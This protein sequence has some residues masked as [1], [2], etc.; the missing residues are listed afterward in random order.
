MSWRTPCST[1]M[2]G[3]QMRDSFLVR[4]VCFAIGSGN[5]ERK[6]LCSLIRVVLTHQ[7]CVTYQFTAVRCEGRQ[8]AGCVTAAAK[9][10]LRP[11]IIILAIQPERPFPAPSAAQPR[12]APAPPR[13][14]A[15]PPPTPPSAEL[16][17]QPGTQVTLGPQS[18]AVGRPELRHLPSQHLLEHLPRLHLLLHLH[19]QGR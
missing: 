17:A 14:S 12:F 11:P 4:V 8:G 18:V 16:A 5:N 19:Q 7:S 2:R 15:A 9:V 10:K 6:E 1:N 3:S 13:T